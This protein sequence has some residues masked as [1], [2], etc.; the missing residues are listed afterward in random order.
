M[1]HR[2]G[3]ESDHSGLWTTVKISDFTLREGETQVGVE[4]VEKKRT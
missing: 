4:G 3:R 2:E 1:T